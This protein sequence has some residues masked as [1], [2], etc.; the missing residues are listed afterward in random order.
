MLH[1]RTE[2]MEYPQ[3]LRIPKSAKKRKRKERSFISTLFLLFVVIPSTIL[4]YSHWDTQNLVTTTHTINSKKLP[5]SFEGFRIVQLSDIHGK[6][7]GEHQERLI[8]RVREAKPDII[9][10]SGDSLDKHHENWDNALLLM[11]EA[12]RIAP[13]YVTLGNHES[14][15]AHR[16]DAIKAI[17]GT[18][19]TL[20]ENKS[21]LI[22]KND[23]AIRLSGINDPKFFNGNYYYHESLDKLADLG[24]KDF[25]ILVSHRPELFDLY[26]DR[27][28]DL[29]FAGHAHGGQA[30]IPFIGPVLSPHQGFFPEFAESVHVKKSSVLVVSRGLGNQY[31]VPRIFNTPEVVVVKLSRS[32]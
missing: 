29:T 10:I 20:L 21:V 5:A 30:R 32:F 23:A 15:P 19:V 28:F 14:I 22:H 7:F 31:P 13:V 3:S 24:H 4:V 2:V 18:G 16:S 25:H 9:V 12:R 1:M 6:A 26:A 8:Q 27:G 17:K 11:K